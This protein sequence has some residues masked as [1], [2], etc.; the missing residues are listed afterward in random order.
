MTSL[1]M[2]FS[3][4]VRNALDKGAP[5]VALESTIIT[6]GMPF[7]QNLEMARKVEDVIRANGAVPATIAVL[8]GE[9]H[10]GL[11]DAQLEQ[12]AQTTDAV[13]TSSRDLAA[14]MVQGLTAGTTVSAT[15]R[16]AALAGIEIF[17]TGGVGGVHRGAEDSF[18]ISADLNELGM[19]NTTVVC[20]GVKSILD[21]PKTLEYLETQR[22][23]IIAHGSDDFPAFFTRSSGCKADHRLNSA[24]EIAKAMALHHALGSGTG[25]LIAN[26]IPEEDALTPEFINGTIEAAVKEA[27]DQGVGGKDVTPF[28]LA[29]INELS[30]G[31]SLKANIAL[32]LNN[33]K[34]A[35]RM[36]VAYKAL[37]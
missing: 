30:E 28:L 11:G 35:A 17:A 37:V 31:R 1:T 23:P 15:M 18:D 22:V 16:I 13:K 33:A 12:L 9:I 3:D 2:H 14:D 5:V 25:I 27:A 7:P 29:R 8:K 32:V 34:L 36:A 26:P 20:A 24:E 6:H 4:E 21:I 10:V 19:T